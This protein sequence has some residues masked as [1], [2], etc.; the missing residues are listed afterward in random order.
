VELVGPEIVPEQYDR[1]VRDSLN[2]LA[3][4]RPDLL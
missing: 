4:V 1:V 3:K 2:A